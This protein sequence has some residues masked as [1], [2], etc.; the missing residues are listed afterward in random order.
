MICNYHKGNVTECNK[1]FFIFLISFAY[2]NDGQLLGAISLDNFRSIPKQL[3]SETLTK[4]IS[5]K[6]DTHIDLR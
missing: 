6:E 4:V 2:D 5:G 1:R 3:W